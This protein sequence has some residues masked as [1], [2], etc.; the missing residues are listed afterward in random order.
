MRKISLLT[1]NLI[2]GGM[3]RVVVNLANKFVDNGDSVSVLLIHGHVANEYDNCKANVI[4]VTDG[5]GLYSFLELS[6]KL[7][8][9]LEDYDNIII[10]YYFGDSNF[11]NNYISVCYLYFPNKTFV[12][13]HNNNHKFHLTNNKKLSNYLHSNTPNV[14]SICNAMKKNMEN[15]YY[16]FNVKTIY[17]PLDVKNVQKLMV[18]QIDEE[19]NYKY[20]LAV[21]RFDYQKNIPALIRAYGLSGLAKQGVKL[22]V[23]GKND[24]FPMYINEYEKSLNEVKKLNLINDIVFTGEKNNVFKYMKNAL[25][26]VMSSRFEGFGMV[27][28]ECLATGTPVISY[29]LKTGP[30]EII[31]HEY[32][33]LLVKDQDEYELSK[34]I[35]RLYFDKD[36]YG[37]CRANALESVQKFNVDNVIKEWEQLFDNA[38]EVNKTTP[39]K[40]RVHEADYINLFGNFSTSEILE[41]IGYMLNYWTIVEYINRISINIC[42]IDEIE[43]NIYCLI[44]RYCFMFNCNDEMKNSIRVNTAVIIML[45]LQNSSITSPLKNKLKAKLLLT[46]EIMTQNTGMTYFLNVK[47]SEISW[48]NSEVYGLRNDRWYKFGRM[49][50]KGKI[51]VLAISFLNPI[52]PQNSIRRDLVK[53][54]YRIVKLIYKCIK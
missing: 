54:A 28:P 22:L 6:L 21:A 32:N 51:K 50:K 34:A 7:K 27:L 44:D 18:E 5:E 35:A 46:N 53:I 42:I 15:D 40:L 38:I 31:I 52:L 26:L 24:E 23:I 2:R 10:S 48:F 16:F 9:M 4:D 41:Y 33:G 36:L 30:G 19:I 3:E 8:K 14:I 49:S 39:R 25:Y 47:N 45:S 29:D 37:R 17:N 1:N 11:F 43:Y 20:I 12:I 13:N